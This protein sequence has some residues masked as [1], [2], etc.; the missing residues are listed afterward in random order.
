MKFQTGVLNLKLAL[1]ECKT[2]LRDWD[3]LQELQTNTALYLQ[4]IDNDCL[5]D[6]NFDVYKYVG[7]CTNTLSRLANQDRERMF[8]RFKGFSG[9]LQYP[10]ES[11]ADYYGS[12]NKYTNPVRKELLKHCI[13]LIERGIKEKQHANRN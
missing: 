6:V 2:V 12:S 5:Y 11:K 10:V 7:L 8:S 3:K 13:Y 1:V 4:P 9:N